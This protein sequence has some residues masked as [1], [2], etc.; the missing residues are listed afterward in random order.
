L[1]S[2]GLPMVTLQRQHRRRALRDR[3]AIAL[4]AGA[5]LLS[6]PDPVRAA[7]KLSLYAYSD[8]RALVALVEEAAGLVERDGERAF[9]Q[10]AVKGSKWLN[11]D[12]YFF[13]YLVD[14][15]CVF[16]PLTPELVGKNVLDLRDLNGKPIIQ[17]IV[18]IGKKPGADASGWVFYLWENQIQ[19]TPMWKSTYVRKV[20]APDGKTY[21]IGSGLYH[22]KMER[23]FIEERVNQA[24]D[25]LKAEGKAAAFKQFQ[26][27]ASP[28]FFLNTYIFVLN[29]Q[30]ETL[31]DPAFPTL[32]GRNLS[33]FQDAVG[34]HAIKEVL[35]K[36]ETDDDAWVQYLWRKAGS[37]LPSRKLLYARKLTVDGETLIVGSDFFLA[38]PIWM[39][40]EQDPAW[41]RN[42]RG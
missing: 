1:D 23:L 27:P 10:F 21:V 40:V 28:F 3:L 2:T 11:G 25:T 8:T 9:Q 18:D 15:T 29:G 16:H 30:G 31:V 26:D 20:V 22:I 39:R 14:G 41:P 19:L 38:T 42:L 35:R 7:D 5:T 13:A 37:P 17:S 24:A 32:A 36:L 4:I 12:I 6:A 34:F 33:D